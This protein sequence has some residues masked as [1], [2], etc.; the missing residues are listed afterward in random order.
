MASSDHL[1]RLFSDK[2]LPVMVIHRVGG[3]RGQIASNLKEAG[4][5][6]I[7]HASNI[8][9]ATSILREAFSAGKLPGW[10]LTSLLT[11]DRFNGVQLGQFLTN[12]PEF[13]EVLWSAIVAPDEMYAVP[14]V[15]ESGALSWHSADAFAQGDLIKAEINKLLQCVERVEFEHDLVSLRHARNYLRLYG[16]PASLKS[17]T[18]AL[19]ELKPDNGELLID[20]ADA[21]A[22]N[23]ELDSAKRI[24]T[25]TALADSSLVARLQEIKG[26]DRKPVFSPEEI[27]QIAGSGSSFLPAFGISRCIIADQDAAVRNQLRKAVE[28]L[29]VHEIAE[30]EDG[31]SAWEFIRENYANSIIIS[32]WKLPKMSGMALLQRIHHEGMHGT[33]VIVSSDRLGQNDL[34]LLEE[35]GSAVLLQKPLSI[36]NLESNIQLA[37]REERM[38]TSYKGAMRQTRS[39]LRKGDIEVAKQT[40]EA[41]AKEFVIPDVHR[42]TVA[43]ELLFAAG[44]IE[45]AYA[46]AQDAVRSGAKGAYFYNLMGRILFALNDFDGSSGWFEKANKEV[47]INLSRLTSMA[48]VELHRGNIEQ[49]ETRASA[50]SKIDSTNVLV[51]EAKTMIAL[52]K[53]DQGEAKALMAQ[54]NEFMNVVAHL[55]NRAVT[56]AW[57]GNPDKGIEL[58]REALASAPPADQK[59]TSKLTPFV[60]YNLALALAR[61]G[62]LAGAQKVIAGLQRSSSK[63]VSERLLTKIGAFSKRVEEAIKNGTKLEIETPKTSDLVKRKIQQIKG[64]LTQPPGQLARSLKVMGT[65]DYRALKLVEQPLRIKLGHG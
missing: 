15:I 49:A 13:Q 65:L 53:G 21:L 57:K 42:N 58:Y 30:F 9:E 28:N 16:N 41:A 18:A 56:L 54:L 33:P 27:T 2:D 11:V 23:G 37:V 26:A 19:I 48:E 63:G 3:I 35:L 61:K 45:D 60:S 62:D 39:L 20:Y 32:E 8:E 17:L 36:R 40:W 10:I 25:R 29:G 55:N 24:A 64:N 34:G 1:R 43:A 51:A 50:A 38:P 46:K 59:D 31:L 44:M 12:T 47:P 52:E 5:S 22:I 14:L 6:S 4:F 7:I